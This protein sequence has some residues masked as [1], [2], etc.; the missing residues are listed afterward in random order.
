MQRS[1]APG[2]VLHHICHTPDATR[3]RGVVYSEVKCL[4]RKVQ[5]ECDITGVASVLWAVSSL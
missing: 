1:G 4:M 2:L 5:E 3:P